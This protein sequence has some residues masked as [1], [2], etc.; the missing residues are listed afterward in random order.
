MN[1]NL[2]SREKSRKFPRIDLH[3]HLD[4]SLTRGCLEELLGRPIKLEELQ[5]APDCKNLAEYLEKFELP[6][7]CLQNA[8]GLRRAGY[9]FMEHVAADHMDY[10]EVRFAPLL[11][12]GQGMKT[13]QVI[14]SVL[15]GLEK[16]K[17]DFGVEYGVIVC[18]MRHHSQEQNL[19]MVKAAAEFLGH[20]VCAADL[21][22]NEAAFPMSQF[23]E[24]FGEV[25]KMGMPFT[26]H[27]GECGDVQNIVDS[28]NCGAGRIGHGIA[29]KGHPEVLKLCK[30]KRIGIEMCPVSNLQ[31]RAVKSIAEYPIREFLDAGLLVTLNTDNRTVSGT[32][33]DKE[34]S[35]VQEAC[36]VTD[37]EIIGIMKNA[38]EVAFASDEVKDRLLRWR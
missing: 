16:G 13:D 25:K 15:E 22:G 37:E 7:E 6:L 2:N 31:T 10:V 14:E 33:L 29:M 5:A 27:A 34:I 35:L 3:C 17:K 21:A 38:V 30:E 32:C 19:G 1:E 23:M 11:S 20:G 9:D 36:G 28:I 26:L 18:A 8:S 4:G 12:C 24:L